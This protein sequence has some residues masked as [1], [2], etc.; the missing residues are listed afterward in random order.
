MADIEVTCEKCGKK[1]IVSEFADLSQIYCKICNIPLKASS[2]HTEIIPQQK[3]TKRLSI[4]TTQGVNTDNTPRTTQ[5]TSVLPPTIARVEAKEPVKISYLAR[6]DVISWIIF[7]LLAPLCAYLRYSGKVSF[8][9]L[10]ILREY[11]WII[12]L[13]FH[14]LII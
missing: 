3:S 11:G 9:W 13:V 5:L 12:A 10:L 14:V 7:L 6:H 2:H 4:K 1:I 8:S